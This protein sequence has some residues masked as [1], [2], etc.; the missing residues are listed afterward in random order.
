MI[1]FL[2]STWKNITPAAAGINAGRSLAAALSES[3]DNRYRKADAHQD[4]RF[5]CMHG[6]SSCMDRV[7]DSLIVKKG[8]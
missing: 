3:R 2:T 7:S 1:L 4:P 6:E 5:G 8:V